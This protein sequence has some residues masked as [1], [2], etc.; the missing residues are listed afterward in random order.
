MVAILQ[1][2]SRVSSEREAAE[3]V[4]L[5]SLPQRLCLSLT[6]LHGDGDTP[7]SHPSDDVAAWLQVYARAI[8]LN[9][10]LLSTLRYNYVKDALDFVGCHQH[11]MAQVC[12][13][14]FT[15]FHL[16]QFFMKFLFCIMS[17]ASTQLACVLTNRY[18]PRQLSLFVLLLKWP[19]SRTIGS[20]I[21]RLPS[22][23]SW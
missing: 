20:Y 19:T 11:R 17:S 4:A 21:Y 10:S 2:F 1:L 13:T 18:Y 22:R 14:F 5:S 3:V 15:F 12:F 7:L 6:S 9:T 23:F 8:D 16:F